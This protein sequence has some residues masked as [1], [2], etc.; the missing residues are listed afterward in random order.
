MRSSYVCTAI[1]MALALSYE[2]RADWN[3]TIA[4]SGP[5]NWYQF[6]ELSGATAVDH[7]S[8]HL[9]GAYG[10]GAQDAMRGVAGIVGTAA[11]FGNQSTVFLHGSDVT[12]NWSAEFVLFRTG[13]KQSSV[14]IRGVPLTFPSEALKLEQFQNTEQFGFT[15]YGVSD[16]GFSPPV[17]T[18]LNQWIDVVYVR[19][20]AGMS[21]YLNGT[22]AGTN[23]TGINLPRDQIGSFSDTIPESPLAIM[24]EAVLYNRALSAAEVAAHFASIPEPSSLALAGIALLGL[25]AYSVCA[26]RRLPL[27]Q[28]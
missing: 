8:Q 1:A 19:S 23:S 24:D 26:R 11:Q 15:Q 28:Q 27:Q 18:P 13:S 22:L 20:G 16:Y 9:D 2:A 10:I 12:G 21:L 14:L 3:S 5:L 4:A 17:P 6:N 7:G 25:S